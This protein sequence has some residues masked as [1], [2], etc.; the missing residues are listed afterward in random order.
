MKNKLIFFLHQ[1]LGIDKAIAYTISTRVVQLLSALFTVYFT[2][3]F[4]SPDEQGYYFTFSSILALQVFFELGFT[5]IITQYVAHEVSHLSWS[6][7][8]ELLGSQKYKS[9]LASLIRLCLKWYSLLS[10]FL[11][12]VLVFAGI[13]FF[14]KFNTTNHNI[15]W[16]LPW[17]LLVIGTC[18]NFLI[19]PISSFLE[20]L[21][22]VKEV[23]KIR[24]LQQVISPIIYCVGLAMGA[25]LFVSAFMAFSTAIIFVFTTYNFSLYKYL[26]TIWKQE[27]EEHISYLNEIF[28]YQWRIALSWI[29]GYFIFQLFNPILFAS[30][31]PTVAGQMGISVNALNSLLALAY[32]WINTK[33]PTLSGYIAKKDFVSLDNLF[34]RT[35]KQIIFISTSIILSFLL[36]VYILQYFD[37]SILGSHIGKRFLSIIP[38]S[39]ISFAL[40][41]QVPIYTWAVYLRC[42]KKEPLL[43]T[44]IVL[45]IL[46]ALSAIVL[47]KLFGLYGLVL[48]FFT[49][50]ITVGITWVYIIFNKKR[51]EWHEI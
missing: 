7:K 5:G 17:I 14:Q 21:G 25:K 10:I 23:A 29:S 33:I 31:G 39:I 50:Q 16:K 1:K 20:G 22:K 34:F 11:L 40:L 51:K 46:S 8:Y 36:V 15:N 37:I 49:I 43:I 32:S 47:G 19:A 9:R 38:L 45:G 3:K 28:P 48:G 4:F 44:S 26:K 6:L 27:I 24:F 18:L 35:M 42:H 2:T 41:L 30:E 12:I 13:F